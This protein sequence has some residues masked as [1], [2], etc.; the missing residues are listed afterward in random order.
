MSMRYYERLLNAAW[1]RL[2]TTMDVLGAQ[3]TDNGLTPAALDALLA[4]GDED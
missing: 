4:D 3:A 2:G 1:E